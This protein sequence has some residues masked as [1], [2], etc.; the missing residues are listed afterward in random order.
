[1]TK[2]GWYGPDGTPVT[3]GQL[4]ELPIPDARGA[5]TLGRVELLPSKD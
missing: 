1:V 5:A 3:E 4:L 2:A